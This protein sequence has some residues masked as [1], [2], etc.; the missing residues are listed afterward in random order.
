MKLKRRRLLEGQEA[1]TRSCSSRRTAQHCSAVL[2]PDR[3]CAPAPSWT[4]L[5]APQVHANRPPP[6]FPYHDSCSF[7][8]FSPRLRSPSSDLFLPLLPPRSRSLV[9]RSLSSSLLTT[10]NVC[11]SVN[12]RLEMFIV[13]AA[14][15]LLS[16]YVYICVYIMFL[17][18]L[19]AK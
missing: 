9:P 4:P 12:S 16:I 19:Y 6:S 15:I 7:S 8:S 17:T 1:D 13:C 5:R 3:T 11:S 10:G 14:L 2:H 18:I